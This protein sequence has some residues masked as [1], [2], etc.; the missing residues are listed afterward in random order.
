MSYEPEGLF[1]PFW[2][3]NAWYRPWEVEAATQHSQAAFSMDRSL[4]ALS[5]GRMPIELFQ[6]GRMYWSSYAKARAKNENVNVIDELVS[7]GIAKMLTG[8]NIHKMSNAYELTFSTRIALLDCLTG[9]HILPTAYVS[10]TLVSR[11]MAL[12]LEVH[13][14]RETVYSSYG[15]EPVLIESCYRIL[16]HF[17]VFDG[18][19]VVLNEIPSIIQTGIMDGGGRGEY[20]MRL[21]TVLAW[22]DAAVTRA[23]RTTFFNTP[24]ITT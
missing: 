13:P 23:H 20:L 8:R 3:I 16:F 5:E 10:S 14:S 21:M 19:K 11:H 9:L 22:A 17:G 7:I 15:S 1:R 18:L 2:E 6:I 12:C 24:N 4:R